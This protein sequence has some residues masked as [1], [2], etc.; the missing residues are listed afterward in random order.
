M[1]RSVLK[2]LCAG[3]VVFSLFACRPQSEITTETKTPKIVRNTPFDEAVIDLTGKSPCIVF[4]VI[5]PEYRID[6]SD[7]ITVYFDQ[8]IRFAVNDSLPK[9]AAY[10]SVQNFG[11]YVESAVITLSSKDQADQWSNHIEKARKEAIEQM[12]NRIE[13]ERKARKEAEAREYANLGFKKVELPRIV[14]AH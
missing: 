8:P 9:G 6:E 4:T 2:I 3:M 7:S 5:P 14:R 12:K 10:L 1:K 11:R 13:K